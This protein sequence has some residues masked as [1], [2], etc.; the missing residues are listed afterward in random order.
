MKKN[1]IPIFATLA[2]TGCVS[3][4]MPSKLP[5][6]H[7]AN[8]N[9]ASATDA[10]FAPFLMADTNLV[11]MTTAETNAPAQGHGGHTVAKPESKIEHKHEP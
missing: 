3:G 6:S 2:L 10:P 8:P 4:T 11:A 1:L 7:P 9:A 5:E